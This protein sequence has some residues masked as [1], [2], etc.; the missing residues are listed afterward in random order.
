MVETAPPEGMQA[1]SSSDPSND[2]FAST[3]HVI[4]EISIP[5]S[6]FKGPNDPAVSIHVQDHTDTAPTDYVRTIFADYPYQ[7]PKT[8]NPPNNFFRIQFSSSSSYVVRE[9]ACPRSVSPVTTDGKF[10]TPDEWED[11]AEVKMATLPKEGQFPSEAY[12]RTKHDE[13]RVYFMWDFLT[14]SNLTFNSQTGYGDE[15]FVVVD[16]NHDK[17]LAP[18]TDDFLI[19]LEWIKGNQLKLSKADWDGKSFR[20]S[21]AGA[22]NG[23]SSLSTSSHS[24]SLHA[25]YEVAVPIE[26]FQGSETV[27]L[28]AFAYDSE[29]QPYTEELW[30][31]GF[32]KDTPATWGDMNFLKQTET[33]QSSTSITSSSTHVVSASTTVAA[34]TITRSSTPTET[35]TV[36]EARSILLSGYLP[37]IMIVVIMAILVGGIMLRKK[38]QGP[39]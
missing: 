24:T 8:A 23:S 38:R 27:G 12:F 13:T 16:P 3:P 37:I 19:T 2:Q 14:D 32:H 20:A 21:Y 26:Y 29:K 28:A 39:G 1:A 36:S 17:S 35:E 18:K 33:T 9:I 6:M 34:S 10:T 4:Y 7:G 31:Y 25:S 30:P 5:R 11:A 22:I 15:V